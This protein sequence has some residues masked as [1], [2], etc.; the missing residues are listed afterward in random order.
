M[1]VQSISQQ[2][3][4]VM[5]DPSQLIENIRLRQA[6]NQVFCQSTYIL[7]IMLV[8]NMR[9]IIFVLKMFN[10]LL[11]SSMNFFFISTMYC[12]PGHYYILIVVKF[13][14]IEYLDCS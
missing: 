9:N 3:T 6:S 13:E 8:V 5:R 12:M 7:L 4:T 11:F 1:M 10:K 2:L 14:V